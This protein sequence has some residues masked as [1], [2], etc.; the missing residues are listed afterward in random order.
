MY[1]RVTLDWW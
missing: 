1:K